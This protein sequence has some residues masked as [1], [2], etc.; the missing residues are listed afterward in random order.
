[1]KIS[2]LL[3]GF[4]ILSLSSQTK[5]QTATNFTEEDCNGVSY[6][7]FDELDAGK[8]I[9]IAWVMPCGSCSYYG[10]GAYDAVQTFTETHPGKVEFYLT[11]DYAN[12]SCT[13]IS[14]WGNTYNMENH[15]AFSSNAISMSDYGT[16]GMPKVV[17]LA[18]N[19]HTVLYNKNNGA[20]SFDGVVEAISLGLSSV[21]IEDNKTLNKTLSIFPNPSNGSMTLDFYMEEN[22]TIEVFTLLGEKVLNV[23]L[24][25]C[26]PNQKN[27]IELNLS[28]QSDGMYLVNL[29]TGTHKTSQIITIGKAT[30]K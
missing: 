1:M 22:S 28:N 12:T 29:N 27:K 4:F 16:D 7:L 19:D 24:D 25:P 3:V 2:S 17:V 10:A 11:D 30:K 18:G 23:N 20:I 5:A 14:N 6:T 21:G 9:V 15:I 8:I 26:T 13:S